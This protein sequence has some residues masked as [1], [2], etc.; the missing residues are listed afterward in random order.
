MSGS[1]WAA[2]G[3][4]GDELGLPG[5]PWPSAHCPASPKLQLCCWVHGGCEAAF[6]PSLGIEEVEQA[7]TGKLIKKKVKCTPHLKQH[8]TP[9]PCSMW[10][11][12]G[13]NSHHE[14]LDPAGEDLRMLLNK[15]YFPVPSFF[16][17]KP[18]SV[19]FG[20]SMN[21]YI[22]WESE[23]NTGEKE[24]GISKLFCKEL[25]KVLLM[26]FFLY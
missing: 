25:L 2:L 15:S 10:Q 4:S 8:K 22:L 13:D 12:T 24:A 17:R 5:A 21:C 6:T 14:L 1:V 26:R 20:I 9:I 16:L 7:G 11:R 18:E 3:L 19:N 23:Y